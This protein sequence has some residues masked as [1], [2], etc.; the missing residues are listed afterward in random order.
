MALQRERRP[1]RF[2]PLL[3]LP[4]HDP[5]RLVHLIAPTPLLI[6]HGA[7]DWL[8]SP[9]HARRLY[10]LAGE[11]RE[12]HLLPAGLHAEYILADD[13]EPL[14]GPLRTFFARHLAASKRL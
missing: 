8:V 1:V 9:D 7:D 12:L 13:P 2:S 14:L 3:L 10:A 5:R 4:G 11:P 6:A